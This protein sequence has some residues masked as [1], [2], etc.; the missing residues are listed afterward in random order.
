MLREEEKITLTEENAEEIVK[1]WCEEGNITAL[2]RLEEILSEEMGIKRNDTQE[3][4]YSIISFTITLNIMFEHGNSFNGI[5]RK[6]NDKI[7][8]LFDIFKNELFDYFTND[9][10]KYWEKY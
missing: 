9:F 10:D 1:L 2:E 4:I 6:H 3:D 8:E 5:C 7:E